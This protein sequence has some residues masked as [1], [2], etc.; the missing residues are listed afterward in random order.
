MSWKP[1]EAKKAFIPF[2]KGTKTHLRGTTLIFCR[3]AKHSESTGKAG[4]SRPVTVSAVETYHPTVRASASPLR[5]ELRQGLHADRLQ[6]VTIL[7]A[8][9]MAM[10]TLSIDALSA[11]F[12][13]ARPKKS[14]PEILA[15]KFT[16]LPLQET[17]IIVK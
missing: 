4:L 11:V 17:K 15:G 12:Y 7:S 5:S 10:R 14:T 16:R 3:T 8:A 9:R 6:P 1:G 2:A 13:H